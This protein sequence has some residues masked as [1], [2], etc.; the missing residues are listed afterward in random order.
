M[1]F[2]PPINTAGCAL[3]SLWDC[4]PHPSDNNLFSFTVVAVI[5]PQVE[6]AG[7]GQR[8]H[9]PPRSAVSCQ[10]GNSCALHMLNRQSA[11]RSAARR[12]KSSR[13]SFSA[14]PPAPRGGQQHARQQTRSTPAATT[15]RRHPWYAHAP[16]VLGLARPREG[17]VSLP[18][19]CNCT[20]RILGEKGQCKCTYN[21]AAYIQHADMLRFSS[22]CDVCS[23]VILRVLC[24]SVVCDSSTHPPLHT[25]SF[26][27]RSCA[28]HTHT[29]TRHQT[30][31][32]KEAPIHEPLHTPPLHAKT[33]AG[34]QKKTTCNVTANSACC[35][36]TDTVAESA[37]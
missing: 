7:G 27:A 5:S 18:L 24:A 11:G 25:R 13:R 29:C 35:A 21:R 20:C 23:C 31:I 37:E 28:P 22:C 9:P 16:L 12:H 26:A 30:R 19:I 15:V 3:G 14:T 33:A 36:L 4:E 17:Q 32:L 34:T 6:V 8:R 10:K 2:L 1:F